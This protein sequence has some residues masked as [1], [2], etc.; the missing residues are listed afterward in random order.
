MWGQDPRLSPTFAAPPASLTSPSTYVA[1]A[2]WLL[3]TKWASTGWA[4]HHERENE[5]AIMPPSQYPLQKPA[6][7]QKAAGHERSATNLQPGSPRSSFG[8]TSS[9]WCAVCP[10]L[11][12]H[13]TNNACVTILP[14]QPPS[15]YYND[16]CVVLHRV[17]PLHVLVQP[18]G[19]GVGAHH[20]T[21]PLM[22]TSSTVPVLN[23]LAIQLQVGAAWAPQCHQL[24]ALLLC[25]LTTG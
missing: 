19:N 23:C 10:R 16:P 25:P 9:I 6:P 21:A 7:S 11:V 4:A 5:M 3:H 12:C 17:R 8:K 13:P 24:Q 14:S 1:T 15:H 22:S 2:A 20:A 18:S